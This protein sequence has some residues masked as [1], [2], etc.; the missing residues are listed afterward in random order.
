MFFQQFSRHYSVAHLFAPLSQLLYNVRGDTEFLSHL[1]SGLTLEVL[2]RGPG[3]WG[4]LQEKCLLHKKPP[5]A[6]RTASQGP[7]DQVAGANASDGFQLPVKISE[8]NSEVLVII[9]YSVEY[10]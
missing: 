4:S 3:T 7:E 5:V 9:R 8:S 1:G 2:R 10:K 6:S